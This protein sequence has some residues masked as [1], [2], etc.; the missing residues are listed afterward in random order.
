M[1]KILGIVDNYPYVKD[2]RKDWG[3]S[4]FLEKN[5]KKILFDTG[6][7]SNILL[8][9]ARV[10]HVDLS[11]IDTLFISHYH[12]D[13]TG[14]VKEL[15]EVNDHLKAYVPVPLLHEDEELKNNFKRKG[16]QVVECKEPLEIIDGI[17][18]TGTMGVEIPEHSLYFISDEGSVLVTG[19]AHP[20]IESIISRVE[21]LTGRK[22]HM[23]IG[24]FHLYGTHGSGLKERVDAIYATGVER[25]GPSH[26]TGDN[27]R[28]ALE[29]KFGNRY[30]K[31]GSGINLAFS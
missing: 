26:C 7:D 18:S 13:H 14:G 8:N 31:F 29:E 27:G 1:F 10:L 16:I 15:L 22:V 2:L 24:G 30:V 25:V 3:F 19:C 23:A 21:E 9:N 17:Y 5:G 11:S 12:Y 20:G 28:E 4:A 6:S